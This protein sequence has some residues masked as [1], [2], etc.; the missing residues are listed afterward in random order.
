MLPLFSLRS[1]YR[2]LDAAGQDREPHSGP[3][4]YCNLSLDCVIRCILRT[5]ATILAILFF[6][7][8]L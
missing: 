5:F 3:L 1:S 4:L 7:R 2:F 6:F 8:F